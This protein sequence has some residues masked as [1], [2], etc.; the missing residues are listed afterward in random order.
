MSKKYITKMSGICVWYHISSPIFHRMCVWSIHTF[1]YIDM[2]D[3]A[4]SYGRFF[5]NFN[6]LDW[7][8]PAKNQIIPT[9]KW[10]PSGLQKLYT[11]GQKIVAEPIFSMIP[12]KIVSMKA[13]GVFMRLFC[14]GASYP[15]LVTTHDI[16]FEKLSKLGDFWRLF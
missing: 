16:F 11:F 9:I 12:Y 7:K 10:A 15:P 3:I 8:K 6:V 14:H 4:K 2:P 1:W 13:W 5:G